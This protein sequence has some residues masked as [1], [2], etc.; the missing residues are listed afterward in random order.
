VKALIQRLYAGLGRQCPP[1]LDL[2]DGCLC[3]RYWI[4]RRARPFLIPR[5][6]E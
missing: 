3:A 5:W 1:P 6:L 2:P 4:D